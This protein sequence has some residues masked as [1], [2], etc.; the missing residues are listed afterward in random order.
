MPTR[1]LGF[2]TWMWFSAP[3]LVRPG[4][5][6][7]GVPDRWWAIDAKTGRLAAYAREGAVSMLR[8]GIGRVA[9]KDGLIAL[10]SSSKAIEEQQSA[11]SRLTAAI[12][13]VAE[14]FFE[15]RSAPK[16]NRNESVEALRAATPSEIMPFYEALTP[17]FFAWLA[18]P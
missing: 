2:P 15:D 5:S 13:R 8:E 12:D 7:I 3:W 17:D 9:A 18:E 16:S 11:L 10:T 1:R 4:Q 14:P 6:E